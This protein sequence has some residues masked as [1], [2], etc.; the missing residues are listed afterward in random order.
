MLDMCL[1]VCKRIFQRVGGSDMLTATCNT[2]HR[3]QQQ[4][5][6]HQQHR[7]ATT[8]GKM[9]WAGVG[10]GENLTMKILQSRVETS[11]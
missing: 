8:K 1:H 6:R 5:Q 11:A 9:G 2:S 4:H 7:R 3:S 10:V